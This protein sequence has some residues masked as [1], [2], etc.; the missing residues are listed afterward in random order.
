MW[1][2][3]PL[4]QGQ[5]LHVQ[6]FST[7]V[8]VIPRSTSSGVS[9]KGILHVCGGDPPLKDSIPKAIRYSPRMWRWSWMWFLSVV[10]LMVFST[11]VEV[12]LSPLVESIPTASIL[13][14]CGG[15]PTEVQTQNLINRYSPRMWRWSPPLSESVIT[16]PVFST[17]VEVILS[18]MYYDNNGTSI[19]HVCGGDPKGKSFV[20][21]NSKYSPRMWRW[22]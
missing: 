3:S 19:L 1:R 13:H 9:I 8:E 20:K 15:D 22:S 2:W 16:L 14:V 11:Y 10:K 17:Y 7:Y 21:K 4:Q 18:V 12:I 5:S 6:V